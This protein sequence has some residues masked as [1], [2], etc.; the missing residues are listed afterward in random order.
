[1]GSGLLVQG[2][3][4]RADVPERRPRVRGASRHLLIAEMPRRCSTVRSRLFELI[5]RAVEEAGRRL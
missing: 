3:L 2:L 5:G 4:G 1:V